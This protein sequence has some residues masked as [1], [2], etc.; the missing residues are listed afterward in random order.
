MAFWKIK[1]KTLSNLAV[2]P[3]EPQL[4]AGCSLPKAVRLINDGD[5]F[6]DKLGDC[7]LIR[8]IG[9]KTGIDVPDM[10]TPVA[11]LRGKEAREACIEFLTRNGY[12]ETSV[13]GEY[14]REK[15]AK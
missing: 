15:A 13:V 10:M 5:W 4:P 9:P 6:G 7:W 8:K 11:P 2:T 14:N 3:G 1:H 12:R